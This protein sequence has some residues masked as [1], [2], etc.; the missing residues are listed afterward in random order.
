MREQT[1]LVLLLPLRLFMGWV[2]LTEALAKLAGG[3]LEQKRLYALAQS[4]LKDGKTYDFYAPFLRDVVAQNA[5][6]FGWLV[7]G[8]EL[9]VG[10]ALLAGLFTRPAALGGILLVANF[11]FARGDGAGANQTAP[12]LAILLTL[13]FTNPGR[14][15][16][17][18]AALKGKI[19]GWL[20]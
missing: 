10:A 18:D 9:V 12:F 16:G 13:L 17:V 8:G 11:L 20:S 15:L 7:I 2:F 4:W 14:T 3:W 6:L 19:P 1:S 5:H